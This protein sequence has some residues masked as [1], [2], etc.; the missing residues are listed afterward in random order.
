MILHLCLAFALVDC[1]MPKFK[2]SKSFFLFRR[3]ILRNRVFL[4][5]HISPFSLSAFFWNIDIPVLTLVGLYISCRKHIRN[6]ASSCHGSRR[7]AKIGRNSLRS[8]AKNCY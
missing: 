3:S 4:Y 5:D 7:R 6:C 2:Q 8:H 1:A